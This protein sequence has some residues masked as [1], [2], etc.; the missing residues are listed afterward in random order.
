MPAASRFGGLPTTP[1]GVFE[2]TGFDERPG[3]PP[4]AAVALPELDAVITPGSFF[5]L[6]DTL[7]LED[8]FEAAK[9]A[10]VVVELGHVPV[11]AGAAIPTVP[12][13]DDPF[14]N[15]VIADIDAATELSFIKD[16]L[17]AVGPLAAVVPKTG[18]KRKVEPKLKATA[19]GTGSLSKPRKRAPKIPVPEELKDDKYWRKRA[20]NNEAA[21]RNRA[22]KKMEKL[23]EAER[24]TMLNET[25]TGLVDEVALLQTELKALRVALRDRLL[26]E[27]LTSLG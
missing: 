9:D 25:H 8:M 27:G 7:R 16:D 19:V 21:R 17:K 6:A 12:E 3:S 10:H 4:A 20:R 14:F 1:R 22:R 23:A 2:L 13:L 15:D 11:P 24:L 18:T 5:D 26:R